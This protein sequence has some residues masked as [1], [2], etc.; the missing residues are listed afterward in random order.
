MPGHAGGLGRQATDE[1]TGAVDQGAFDLMH[2]ISRQLV[3]GKVV[4]VRPQKVGCA[5]HEIS[6]L[7][8]GGEM[9]CCA[10]VA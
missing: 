1:A 4:G 10:P 2:D 6:V 9:T 3:I 8:L 5:I 7:E